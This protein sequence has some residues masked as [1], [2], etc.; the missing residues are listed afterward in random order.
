[1]RNTHFVTFFSF[2]FKQETDITKMSDNLLFSYTFLRM[3]NCPLKL[4]L[5]V[6]HGNKECSCRHGPYVR[7]TKSEGLGL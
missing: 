2:N 5:Y 4:S 3:L 1:M 7:E 6:P